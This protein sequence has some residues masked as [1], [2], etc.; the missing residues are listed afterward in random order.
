MGRSPDAWRFTH[1]ASLWILAVLTTVLCLAGDSPRWILQ[2]AVWSGLFALALSVSARYHVLLGELFA[3][4]T[5][6]ERFGAFLLHCFF[7]IVPLLFFRVR[8]WF[9]AFLAVLLLVAL[10][11][12]GPRHGGR[13]IGLCAGLALAALMPPASPLEW[14]VFP[15]LAAALFAARAQHVRFLLEDHDEQFGPP[16]LGAWR[17]LAVA[18]L[19][20]VAVGAAVYAVGRDYLVPRALAFDAPSPA[21]RRTPGQSW[22]SMN[23]ALFDGVVL[24][25][26]VLGLLVLVNWMDKWLRSRRKAGGDV[27]TLGGAFRQ[28]I[29]DGS[30]AGAA[31]VVDPGA[32][33]R[34]RILR[35]FANF[36]RAMRPFGDSRRDAETAAEYLD[37]IHVPGPEAD[38]FDRACYSNSEIA[39]FDADSFERAVAAELESTRARDA[40][41]RAAL[42]ERPRNTA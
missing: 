2:A 39:P 17:E 30:A 1:L 9:H 42:K 20:P 8:G 13:F 32:G 19:L 5:Y 29:P 36:T 28:S 14:L 40:E 23:E 7:L 33:D 26:L 38:A 15:W 12:V 24:L 37:R 25:A 18:L 11:V 22:F 16:L 35:A 6:R 21:V 4:F 27:V 10:H 34:A 31:A 41:R 3:Q